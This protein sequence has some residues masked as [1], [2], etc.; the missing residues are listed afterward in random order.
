MNNVRH[1]LWQRKR[2]LKRAARATGASVVILLVVFVCTD[3]YRNWKSARLHGA[4]KEHLKEGD[5]SRAALDAQA[6]LKENPSNTVARGTLADAYDVTNDIRLLEVLDQIEGEDIT[7]RRAS[8][9]LRFGKVD[10]AE[11]ALQRVSPGAGIDPVDF[12][13]LGATIALAKA[14]DGRL[15]GHYLELARHQ[16]SHAN[17]IKLAYVDLRTPDRSMPA[18]LRRDLEDI[19]VRESGSTGAD[20]AVVAWALT[21]GH[22]EESESMRL[23]AVL[24]NHIAASATLR[25]SFLR[26]L[27]LSELSRSHIARRSLLRSLQDACERIGAPKETLKLMLWMLQNRRHTMRGLGRF[28]RRR[29]FCAA[30]QPMRW[31]CAI[32][33]RPMARRNRGSGRHSHRLWHIWTGANSSSSGML[34]TAVRTP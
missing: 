4:A 31:F 22:P 11:D 28:V 23:R 19:A 3:G 2:R 10:L 33:W 29:R 15:Y 18:A 21:L 7:K 24:E 25:Q 32:C 6:A 30:S 12:H 13:E 16:K 9:A 26:A 1:S 8:A 27:E 14:D 17:L 34:T 20:A 5:F